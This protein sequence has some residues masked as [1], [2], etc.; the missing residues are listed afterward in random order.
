MGFKF[1]QRL[2]AA[3]NERRNCVEAMAVVRESA[4]GIPGA[5]I[6]MSKVVPSHGPR[7][8][9]SNIVGKWPKD[10]DAYVITIPA[11]KIK[12]KPKLPKLMQAQ[13]L[14]WTKV[15][16]SA[17]MAYWNDELETEHDLLNALVK[18]TPHQLMHPQAYLT[19]PRIK[20]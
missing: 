14:L 20:G 8:K 1:A 9:V 3:W 18:L 10:G 5:V 12:S 6:W 7:I 4:V 19:A 13:I 15:N 2:I 16:T 17:I 11:L